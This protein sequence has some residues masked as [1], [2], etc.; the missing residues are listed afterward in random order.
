MIFKNADDVSFNV[1]ITIK[2][3]KDLRSVLNIDLLEGSG[4]VI[5]TLADDPVLLADVLYIICKDQAEKKNISDENFGIGLRGQAIE[6]AVNAFIDS[7]IN[8]S[9]P[10]KAALL[11]RA[12]K[13]TAELKT[14]AMKDLVKKI[15]AMDYRSSIN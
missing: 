12:M 7:F 13:K 3:I 14:E 11:T 4:Q 15:D 10:Q 2:T 8:F 9:P 6:D 5:S 1:Q